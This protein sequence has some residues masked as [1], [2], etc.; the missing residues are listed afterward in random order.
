LT[1]L[2]VSSLSDPNVPSASRLQRLFKIWTL[3]EA[4]TKALGQGLGFD[5]RRIEFDEELSEIS[6][7]GQAPD[8]WEFIQYCLAHHE[9]AASVSAKYILTVARFTGRAGVGLEII[10]TPDPN[11]LHSYTIQSLMDIVLG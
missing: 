4:Y 8:G 1:P 9:S 2:E 3:K 7:D 10:S 11:A 6:I 5:F